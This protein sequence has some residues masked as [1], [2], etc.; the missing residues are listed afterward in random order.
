MSFGN[1]EIIISKFTGKC[2]FCDSVEN[3]WFNP[4][5]DDLYVNGIGP[6]RINTWEDCIPYYTHIV[7]ASG[8]HSTSLGSES[9]I[10]TE[11]K[12]ILEWR[13]KSAVKIFNKYKRKFKRF[14]TYD[15]YIIEVS[16]IE[17][18]SYEEYIWRYFFTCLN[19]KKP[20]LM[21]RAHLR[22]YNKRRA[23]FILFAFKHHKC[24]HPQ[25]Y[26]LI[27]ELKEFDDGEKWEHE[28]PLLNTTKEIWKTMEV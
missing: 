20:E 15:E 24:S 22:S 7:G 25:V 4:K 14:P 3:G 18:K 21:E 10:T 23:D 9:W 5:T 2:D 6:L 12:Q 26:K 17:G 19:L 11:E 13:Q 8:G 16:K 1:K 27:W 28:V